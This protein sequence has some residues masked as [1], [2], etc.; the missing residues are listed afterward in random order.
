MSQKS[1]MLNWKGHVPE[2]E[3]ISN[4]HTAAYFFST[5]RAHTHTHTR[6]RAGINCKLQAG[7]PKIEPVYP[8]NHIYKT[9]KESCTRDGKEIKCAYRGIPLF[10]R[11]HTRV[12][13]SRCIS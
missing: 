11:T 9:G 8:K 2:M 5:A 13:S 3:K 10:I 12:K 1:D 7:S 4:V 6:A